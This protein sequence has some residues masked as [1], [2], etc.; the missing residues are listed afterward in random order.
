MYGL[1]IIVLAVAVALAVVI[2]TNSRLT[3][4]RR[5]AQEDPAAAAEYDAA[6]RRLPARLFAR[7]LGFNAL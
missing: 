6:R 5:R 7:A 4:L 3:A 1:I 2:R